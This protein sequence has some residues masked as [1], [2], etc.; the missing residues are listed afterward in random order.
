MDS[1]E[2]ASEIG[3]GTRE[4]GTREQAGPRF[5]SNEVEVNN[6]AD[7]DRLSK[8]LEVQGID[9]REELGYTDLG[10]ANTQGQHYQQPFNSKPKSIAGFGAGLNN[11]L[12]GGLGAAT[13]GLQDTLQSVASTGKNFLDPVFPSDMKS[14]IGFE[15]GG[16]PLSFYETLLWLRPHQFYGNKFTVV[17][18]H[19][20]MQD[21]N[22]GKLG[23]CYLLSAIAAISEHP[24]RIERIIL[25]KDV[26]PQGVYA[27]NICMDGIWQ[28]VV[29]DDSFP[30]FK[31]TKKPAFCSNQS[32]EIWPMLIEKAWAKAHGGYNNIIS[33]LMREALKNLTGAPAAT[34]FTKS[35]DPESHWRVLQD[36]DQK[37]FIMGCASIDVKKSGDDSADQTTGLSGNHA[38]TLIGVTEI[39]TGEG[40]LRV[41]S[42]HE[43]SSPANIR[44]VKLR[45]PWGKGE[46]NGEWS[47]SSPLWTSRVKQELGFTDKD[48]GIFYMGFQDWLNYF[49]EYQICYY[50]D[51]YE[52]SAAMFQSNPH[53]E[54][55]LTFDIGTPGNYYIT[56]NQR[57]KRVFSKADGYSYTPLTMIVGRK[58]AQ[59]GFS[60]VGS[61]CKADNEMWFMADCQ[62]GR[63]VAK[64][65]TPW[66]GNER[67]F[68]LAT[69]GPQATSI[70]EIPSGQAP[71]NLVESAL[72]DKA[73][74]DSANFKNYSSQGHPGI[75][76]KFEIASDSFGYF[77]FLNQSEKTKLD[78]TIEF[79][80]FIDCKVFPPYTENNPVVS[81]QP[82]EQK[83]LVYKME[84]KKSKVAFKTSVQFSEGTPKQEV[85]QAQRNDHQSPD[86]RQ[87]TKQYGQPYPRYDKSGY[88]Y[89]IHLYTLTHEGG[90][91][92]LYEN[93]SD[94][95]LYEDIGFN[96]S[97]A[98]I[99]GHPS[100]SAL[101]VRLG[102]GQSEFFNITKTG[103]N[104]SVNTAFCEYNIY[105]S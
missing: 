18:E 13:S 100:T 40:E 15:E 65:S 94:Y 95:L 59:G 82:G 35:D 54:K 64:V 90:L 88:E 71:Q 41:K 83:I 70:Q 27:V 96:L 68:S 93:Q 105:S 38:Y 19:C 5:V 42:P 52:Y 69:Y 67:K 21:L 55:Y 58:D 22:Q 4:V 63:Y 75:F 16:K 34:Y 46:W 61:V 79:T 77:Y 78:A 47:D 24:H 101:Q 8:E 84:D 12:G 49:R 32:L 57:T 44:L 76:Y 51:N 74:Q 3:K 17:K 9:P 33:G 98:V 97:D 31:K 28:E 104:F 10:Y 2:A 20:T 1:K 102:P 99:E 29:M 80:K 23:D 30:C 62:P 56:V 91:A 66:V 37:D 14:L 25:N 26:N 73:N 92:L 72:C 6:L 103:P 50:H 87:M 85:A 43:A 11:P 60:F 89:P 39:V 86:L 45:N 7:L 36:A 48:D 81:V 53:E